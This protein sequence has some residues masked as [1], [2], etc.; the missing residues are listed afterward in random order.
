MNTAGGIFILLLTLL[1]GVI[2]GL[3]FGP[4]WGV[5]VSAALYVLMPYHPRT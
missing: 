5:A 1:V 3:H 4:E 2:V